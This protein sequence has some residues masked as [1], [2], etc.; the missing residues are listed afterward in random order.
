VTE[1]LPGV[2]NWLFGSDSHVTTPLFFLMYLYSITVLAGTFTVTFFLRNTNPSSVNT[3]RAKNRRL[4]SL[5]APGRIVGGR[6]GQRIVRRPVLQSSDR[7]GEEDVFCK[8]TIFRQ[9]MSVREG[10]QVR[11]PP[12]VVVAWT[13]KVTA[14]V[15]P[16]LLE[17]A[18][19][20]VRPLAP[21]LG[22]LNPLR[23]ANAVRAE[24]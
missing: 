5:T 11:I 8:T 6:Q 17:Q 20:T 21:Q 14:T 16:E 4:R 22:E 10:K 3:H 2:V 1:P 19:G 23:A 13:L 7:S 9:I 24:A 18:L 15:G 12:N